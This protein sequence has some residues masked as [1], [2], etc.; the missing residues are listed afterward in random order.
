VASD[1]ATDV[2]TRRMNALYVA[3]AG[4]AGGSLRT[5]NYCDYRALGRVFDDGGYQGAVEKTH[6]G[7]CFNQYLGTCLQAM[8]V[9]KSE[10]ER[11]GVGG[12]GVKY[13]GEGRAKFYPESIFTP[14]S[15]PLPFLVMPPAPLMLPGPAMV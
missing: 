1:A 10:Y 12:Y 7:L 4:S 6:A 11:D 2:S 8:G 14:M 13:I 9:P 5:G 15:E 3:T